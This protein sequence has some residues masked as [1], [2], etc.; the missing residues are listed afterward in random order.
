M[1]M[2]PKRLIISRRI[3]PV[4]ILLFLLAGCVGLPSPPP[5]PDSEWMLFDMGALRDYY[6][7]S[8]TIERLSETTVKAR[9]ATVIKGEEGRNW[10]VAERMKRG[11]SFGGYEN[12]QSSADVYLID[13]AGKRYQ[14]I[15]GADYDD[16]DNILSSYERPEPAWE[17]VPPGSTLETL[18]TYKAVCP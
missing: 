6:Y 10:E 13:C 9:I 5:P 4:A 11:L 18:L 1:F 7:D 3:L 14:I 12:Y 16:K 8:A 17:P 15:K 2:V